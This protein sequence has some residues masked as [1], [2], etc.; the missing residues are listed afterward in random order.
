MSVISKGF[1]VAYNVFAV[2]SIRPGGSGKMDNGNAYSASVK[3]RSHNV[4]E[5]LDARVGLQEVETAIEFNIPCDSED[6]AAFVSEA[7]R[8]LR[9]NNIVFTISG[10][11]PITHQD[12]KKKD[13]AN[14]KSFENGTEFLKKV[15]PLLVSKPVIK[16]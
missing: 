11:L 8:K 3:F 14:V 10:D 5:R 16:S 9:S 6:Q 12:G 4:V 13:V 2:G 7:V 15:E 1:E